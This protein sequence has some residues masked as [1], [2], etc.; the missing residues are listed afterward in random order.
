MSKLAVLQGG[1][2]SGKR[3]KKHAVAVVELAGSTAKCVPDKRVALEVCDK[4]WQVFDW[5]KHD[6]G[7]RIDLERR[8]PQGLRHRRPQPG[9]VAGVQLDFGVIQSIDLIGG[10]CFPADHQSILP[11]LASRR[12][13]SESFSAFLHPFLFLRRVWHRRWGGCRWSPLG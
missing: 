11:S 12:D 9:F 1:L 13:R 3:C 2:R 8:R 6:H 10:E 7:P 5:E 4:P